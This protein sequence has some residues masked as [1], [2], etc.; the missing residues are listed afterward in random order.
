MSFVDCIRVHLISGC[1]GRGAVHF[2]RTRNS[3]RSGPDG[4]DGGDGG[5]V[6]LSPRSS[7]NN[8]SHLLKKK[9]YRAEDGEPG[10][11]SNKKGAKGKDLLLPV[12]NH[13]FC[14]NLKGD[15]LK[16]LYDQDWQVLTG[17]KGGKGNVFFKTSFRQAPNQYQSGQ[18]SKQ[19]YL[20]LEMKWK[21]TI[22][23]IGPPCSG[24]TSFLF[25][26]I[27]QQKKLKYHSPRL[28]CLKPKEYFFN[29]ITFVDLP[30]LHLNNQKILKQVE[31]SEII[32]FIL[33]VEFQNLLETYR[34]LKNI[35][36]KYDNLHRTHL[37]T[38]P[39]L[40]I[41]TGGCSSSHLLKMTNQL[42]KKHIPC[43]SFFKQSAEEIKQIMQQIQILKDSLHGV[44][45]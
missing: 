6:I 13:T 24:K 3:P 42:K 10:R 21:S 34:D 5:C 29:P 39:H 20:L 22:A 40:V 4:G 33:S 19:K 32:F 41:L 12:P 14:Y 36:K 37:A 7:V 1:G 8:L 35:L 15:L 38:K 17:G 16:T 26:L 27:G 23:L 18:K 30:G 43:L 31:Y 44:N 9:V 45:N 2:Q 28:Y 25:R 11:G